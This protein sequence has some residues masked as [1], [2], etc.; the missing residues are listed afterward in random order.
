MIN[1]YKLG[2]S[3]FRIDI[4]SK[5]FTQV[6]DAEDVS[7]VGMYLNEKTFD[8]LSKVISDNK[9]GEWQGITEEDFNFA[10]QKVL[11]KLN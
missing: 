7:S 2:V 11:N 8:T 4:D 3:F 5:S 9:E 10:R 6:N 1:Y